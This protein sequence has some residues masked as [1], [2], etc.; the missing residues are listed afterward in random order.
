MLTPNVASD[1]SSLVATAIAQAFGLFAAVFIAA[2]VSGGHVNPAV[3]FAF[4]IGGHIAVPSAIFYWASQLLGST[5]ACLVIHFIS[6][7]QAVPTTSIAVEMTGF[8]AAILEGVITFM[9]VYTVHVAG[10]PRACGRKGLAATA[11]GALVVGVVTGAC[12]LAA[13]SLTGA[14]MNPAR[15]FGPAVVSGNFKNQAVYWVGPMIGA[16]VAALVHQ[17]LVFPSAPDRCRTSRGTGAWKQWWCNLSASS[18]VTSC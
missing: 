2:D 4:A 18:F 6:A 11:M 10:D 16:A 8:G 3:T 7:G 13:G 12:V 15:S 17:N 9:L 1:A 14:S 5:L